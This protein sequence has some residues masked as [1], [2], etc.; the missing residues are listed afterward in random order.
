VD[1]ADGCV[2]LNLAMPRAMV[3]EGLERIARAVHSLR[4]DV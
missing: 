1:N 2:R 4:E 3:Q